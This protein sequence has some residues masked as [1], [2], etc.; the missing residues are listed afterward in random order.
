M[1][2]NADISEDSWVCT[3]SH[4]EFWPL[5]YKDLANRFYKM[6]LQL[7][8]SQCIHLWSIWE[9]MKTISYEHW[10]KKTNAIKN[11]VLLQKRIMVNSGVI[12]SPYDKKPQIRR[13][14]SLGTYLFIIWKINSGLVWAAGPHCKWL[15]TNDR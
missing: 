14:M 1:R 4:K 10:F 8:N 12:T 2:K 9:W 15:Q 3:C 7:H 5:D 6:D 13:Q 11:A